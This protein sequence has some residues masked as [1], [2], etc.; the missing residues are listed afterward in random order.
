MVDFDVGVMEIGFEGEIL[1][2]ELGV[3]SKG[4]GVEENESVWC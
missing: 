2:R 1:I 3:R 4:V